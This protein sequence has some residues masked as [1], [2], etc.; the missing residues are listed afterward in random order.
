M[1][2]NRNEMTRLKEIKA[3]TF[4]FLKISCERTLHTFACFYKPT[5]KTS[6]A[7]ECNLASASITIF[8]IIMLF[9]TSL[10]NQTFGQATKDSTSISKNTIYLELFGNGGTGSINYDRIL[11]KK[12]NFKLSSRI[13]G[14]FVPRKDP[15]Y[16]N[17]Q[18]NFWSTLFEINSFWGRKGNFEMGIGVSYLKGGNSGIYDIPSGGE[19]SYSSSTLILIPRILG[20]RFQKPN[21]GFFCKVGIVALIQIAE[22]NKEWKNSLD[23][24]PYASPFFSLGCGYTIIKKNK[25]S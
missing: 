20:Y 10:F 14:I 15:N 13:G 24:R 5:H 8:I 18:N 16:K 12:N 3:R 7:K 23:Y 22:F 1:N 17:R 21:G 4:A 11:M 19:I 25:K 2:K 6:Q 9:G